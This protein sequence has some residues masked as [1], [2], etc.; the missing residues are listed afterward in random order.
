MRSAYCRNVPTPI[1]IGSGV[2]S[3]KR[4]SGGV[5]AS[6]FRGVGEEREHGLGRRVEPLLAA[7]DV[8]VRA[9]IASELR[10]YASR[11]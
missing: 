9:L 8:D 6:R 7:Q 11:R 1:A 4:S 3:R 2:S 10:P 5:I